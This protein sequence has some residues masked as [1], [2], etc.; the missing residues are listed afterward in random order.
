MRSDLT[1]SVQSALAALLVLAC[2]ATTAKAETGAF[3]SSLQKAAS[4]LVLAVAMVF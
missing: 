3:A 4:L 1:R 2:L